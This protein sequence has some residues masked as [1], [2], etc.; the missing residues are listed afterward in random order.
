MDTLNTLNTWICD[1]CGG[2]IEKAEDGWVE[3]INLGI[4]KPGRDLRLVH[5]T[6]TGPRKDK[7]GCMFNKGQNLLRMKEPSQTST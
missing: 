1:F 2:A 6:G 7:G 5:R 4:S 3:W